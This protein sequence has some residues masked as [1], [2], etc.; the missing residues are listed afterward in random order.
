[1]TDAQ[2]KAESQIAAIQACIAI[3]NRLEGIENRADTAEWL[4]N[5]YRQAAKTDAAQQA[6]H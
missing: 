4:A 3:I 5:V 6:G 1:M 2:T